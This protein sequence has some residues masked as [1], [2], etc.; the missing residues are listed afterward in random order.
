MPDRAPEEP[1]APAT[2]PADAAL[3]VLDYAPPGPKRW[4]VGTLSYTAGG[5]V[6]LFC[7]LLWGDFAWSIK[8]RSVSQVTQLMLTKF[9]ASDITYSFLTIGLPQAI[10]VIVYPIVSFKSD[11]HRGH[12]GRRVPYLLFPLP[13]AVGALVAIALSPAIGHA[14]GATD[15][16]RHWWTVFLLG[17]FWAIFEVAAL[18]TNA[19]FTAFVADVVPGPL[20]GRF[21]GAF[22]AISLIA[23]IL[24]NHYIYG[25]AAN[26]YVAI[27]LGV[28]FL[29]GVGLTAMALNVKEGQYPP[30]P[31]PDMHAPTGTV[32]R[33]L[34]TSGTYLAESFSDRYY[35]TIFVAVG[36]GNVAIALINGFN[37]KFS[38]ALHNTPNDFGQWQAITYACS[39][40]QALPVGWLVDRFNTL[41]VALVG[42]MLHAAFAIY[43]GLF[44]HDRNTFAIAFIATGIFSGTFF[45]ATAGLAAKL[46]PRDRFAQ[47][48]AS[49]MIVQSLGVITASQL[50]GFILNVTGHP[51]RQT[52]TAAF[53]LDAIAIV[54]FVVLWKMYLARHPHGDEP[55]AAVPGH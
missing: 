20:L 45:T 28:A 9:Y 38:D 12:L 49:M 17:S 44:I 34:S 39:L 55:T 22:R 30:P 54:G 53:V 50:A 43:G 36:L 24:F 25:Q 40:F 35:V 27:F 8:E 52:Y 46:L 15:H 18:T 42:L 16:L 21:Y 29:Y 26:H 13:F 47:F 14:L 41:R 2:S 32:E 3:P 5:L 19:V 33:F 48:N 23:G 1:A 37:V 4:T 51:Y 6:V 10:T 11:R 7:W 31:P